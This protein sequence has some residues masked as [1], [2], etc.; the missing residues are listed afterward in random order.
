MASVTTAIKTTM[1][2]QTEPKKGETV[3][4]SNTIYTGT[5]C[6]FNSDGKVA[7][8]GA[9][10]TMIGIGEPDG[11]GASAAAGERVNVRYG[12]ALLNVDSGETIADDDC[13]KIAYAKT[14][15]EISLNAGEGVPCGIITGV[16]AGKVWVNLDPA[17]NFNDAT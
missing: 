7:A 14:N 1:R 4:P 3:A 9:G 13:G 5:L 2:R 6:G 17:H 12:D 11:F 15:H 10:I 8:P 16:D